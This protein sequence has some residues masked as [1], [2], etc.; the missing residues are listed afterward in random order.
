M[1]KLFNK[2]MNSN[3]LQ[4]IVNQST[5]NDVYVWLHPKKNQMNVAENTKKNYLKFCNLIASSS[6]H[7][8][9]HFKYP[10]DDDSNK[11]DMFVVLYDTKRNETKRN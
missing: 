10:S 1:N 7:H 5:D 2:W 8:Q 9:Q 6:S 11:Q 4:L 3:E